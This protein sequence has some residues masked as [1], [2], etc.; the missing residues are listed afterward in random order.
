[1]G[2]CGFGDNNS[3]PATGGG[4]NTPNDHNGVGNIN[5]TQAD[6]R[7]SSANHSSHLKGNDTASPPSRSSSPISNPGGLAP[8]RTRTDIH[9]DL[10]PS[11]KKQLPNAQAKA[12]NYLTRPPQAASDQPAP[13][14]DPIPMVPQKPFAMAG[15]IDNQAVKGYGA[16]NADSVDASLAPG[17]QARSSNHGPGN[18]MGQ[19]WDLRREYTVGQGSLPSA[20]ASNYID[21]ASGQMPTNIHVDSRPSSRNQWSSA[22]AGTNYRPTRSPQVA[23][24]RAAP[25]SE[26]ITLTPQGASS[27]T[28][29]H[30]VSQD[31]SVLD[32][33]FMLDSQGSQEDPKKDEGEPVAERLESKNQ[34]EAVDRVRE[35]GALPHIDEQSALGKEKGRVIDTAPEKY[36]RSQSADEGK[37]SK[38]GD[39]M[40]DEGILETELL[41]KEIINPASLEEGG[42]TVERP[43]QV[44]FPNSDAPE[45]VPGSQHQQAIQRIPGL[46]SLQ[47]SSHDNGSLQ[48]QKKQQSLLEAQQCILAGAAAALTVLEAICEFVPVPGLKLAVHSAVQIMKIA[49][50]IPKNLGDCQGLLDHTSTLMIAVITP[51]IGEPAERT[52]PHMLVRVERLAS[53]LTEVSHDLRNIKADFNL[54]SGRISSTLVA[55]LMPQSAQ[56]R[57]NGCLV[58]LTR[59]TQAFQIE[60]LAQ[61]DIDR[62]RQYL[63]LQEIKN[64]VRAIAKKSDLS[65][66][67]A[68]TNFLEQR[69]KPAPARYNSAA[70]GT[71]SG[72]LEGTRIAIL[73]KLRRWIFDP[74]QPRLRIVWLNGQAGTG[75]SAIAHTISEDCAAEG[76]LGAS[77]FFSQDQADRANGLRVLTTIAY[78][79]AR[80][81]PGFQTPLVAALRD[82]PEA[83]SS[84]LLTQLTKLILEPLRTVI[85]T[86]PLPIVIVL[87]ALNECESSAHATDIVKHL[88]QIASKLPDKCRLRVLITSR[89]ELDMQAAIQTIAFDNSTTRGKSADRR[90]ASKPSPMALEI[91]SLDEIDPKIVGDDIKR[92][93]RSRLQDNRDIATDSQIERLVEIAQGLF[94]AASTAVKY[95][96][97]SFL[98]NIDGWMKRLETILSVEG[99][100]SDWR[101]RADG[102]TRL[103]VGSTRPFQ[104]LDSMYSKILWKALPPGRDTDKD[105]E[106]DAPVVLGT[107]TLLFNPLSLRSL[108]ALLELPPRAVTNSLLPFHSVVFV[109]NYDQEDSAPLRLIH[110]SFPNFLTASSRC[111]DT[112][113][114]VDPASQHSRVALLCLDHMSKSLSRDMCNIG[115]LPTP[116]SA[117]T[118]LHKRLQVKVP[119][120]LRYACSSWPLH[121]DQAGFSGYTDN[122]VRDGKASRL[123][124]AFE[125][126][127]RTKLLCWLEVMSLLGRLDAVMPLLRVVNDGLRNIRDLSETLDI[128]R[129]TM[130]FVE[131]FSEPISHSAGAIYSSALLL[132]PQCR[133][134]NQYQFELTQPNVS[135]VVR[136]GRGTDWSQAAS[137]PHSSVTSVAFSPN[138]AYIAAAFSNETA[139]LWTHA[140]VPL[141]VLLG[142]DP[143]SQPKATLPDNKHPS[144]NSHNGTVEVYNRQTG[145]GIAGLEVG[146]ETG[147]EVWFTPDSQQVVF[148]SRTGQR[149]WAQNITKYPV[150]IAPRDKYKTLVHLR[151]EYPWV[152]YLSW[153]LCSLGAPEWTWASWGHQITFGTPSGNVLVLDFS[154]VI[155]VVDKYQN[156]GVTANNPLQ[157]DY[158]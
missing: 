97:D 84:D 56:D 123:L 29:S 75:K 139:Q 124:D 141:A 28:T 48:N 137:Q 67:F 140:G 44:N 66:S 73:Q 148:R 32:Y 135:A 72:C 129:D 151:W 100:D 85:D 76:K 99:N 78:Q 101:L 40:P 38:V 65:M 68:E 131:R 121:L 108:A 69:L 154:S 27:A 59:A 17:N 53:V 49:Q 77:F 106:N 43:I 52:E 93:L 104:A 22:Q 81:I 119:L 51:L 71:I 15:H 147:A 60:S 115:F 91:A 82:D 42:V 35:G 138:G 156:Q 26:V 58:E 50:G 92:Y 90:K 128:I 110:P 13:L 25:S 80:S 64:D 116:N 7:I 125:K 4:T 145:S 62:F 158:A 149:T 70:R 9:I 150:A 143:L 20:S 95:I 86:A 103:G 36:H 113:F 63:E 16:S 136:F 107:I 152:T 45:L 19:R 55:V 14:F 41:A 10:R 5:K 105:V 112:R 127:V 30:V 133:L 144:T 120:H 74:D 2:N 111:T 34:E 39:G 155:R 47:S 132:T 98:P 33:P 6:D 83:S 89:P 87:D 31:E 3:P 126:F 11:R 94:I 24:D 8:D 21:I 23:L 130:H 117:V 96:N 79:L 46:L 146:N 1:M 57:I 134:Y 122:S 114:F 18:W 12:D 102:V 61:A 54:S 157:F 118:D 153:R 142:P 88:A 109:P 37:K